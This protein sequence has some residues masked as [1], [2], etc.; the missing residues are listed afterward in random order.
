M[1]LSK[2]SLNVTKANP[3]QKESNQHKTH[4]STSMKILYTRQSQCE[5][6]IERN[7]N[8]KHLKINN[9]TAEPWDCESR[10]SC[11]IY[12]TA[13][14]LINTIYLLSYV[15]ICKENK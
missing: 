13:C 3:P 15:F 5:M 14:V 1:P 11:N 7:G 12:D 8:C 4:T 10:T 6:E 9:S 2:H